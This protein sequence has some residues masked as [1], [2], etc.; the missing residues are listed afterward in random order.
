MKKTKINSQSSRR[1]KYIQRS[2]KDL[3][4]SWQV[5]ETGKCSESSWHIHWHLPG[6]FLR[7][8]YSILCQSKYKDIY[9]GAKNA[10]KLKKLFCFFNYFFFFYRHRGIGKQIKTIEEFNVCFSYD[11]SKVIF[12][13]LTLPDE[14]PR[15]SLTALVGGRQID[16][17]YIR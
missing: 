7:V 12:K 10:L 1:A 11:P 9:K 2:W 13:N 3:E 4:T 15:Q 14:R 16:F 8:F 6:Y 5:C 17:I